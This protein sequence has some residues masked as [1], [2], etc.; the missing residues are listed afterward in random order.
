LEA[1][2]QTLQNSPLPTGSSAGGHNYAMSAAQANQN[3]Q[4]QISDLQ[5]R[6]DNL[7]SGQTADFTGYGA[8]QVQAETADQ[9]A[10]LQLALEQ[11]Y[12]PQFIAEALKQEQ[13]ADPQ[14][15]AARDRES[16][17]IQQQINHP[18]IN[19]VSPMLESQIGQQV[20][21][22]KGLDDFDTAALNSGVQQALAARGGGGTGAD[23]TAPLTTG[24]E[25]DQ[26]Q[27]AGIQKAQGFMSSG[28]TPEDIKYRQQQQDLANLS[29]EISGQ[30]PTSEFGSLSNASR[31][32]NPTT[33]G[34][35]LPT[36]PGN[37][38]QVGGN[39]AQTRYGQQMNQ[40]NSWMSGLS[41]VVNASTAIAN[42]AK[43]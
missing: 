10:K 9:N 13:L 28:T 5:S 15:V 20:S 14:S 3:R 35:P 33:A 11:K 19:P 29:A 31:S 22:G 36:M 4:Q 24:F 25:G 7:K 16:Q 6:I 41:G 17:L 21:A 30:T 40:A 23:F 42:A 39:A 2:L 26:R 34:A 43:P 37:S 1:Q 38:L 8:G 32:A 12:S 18:V 27:L